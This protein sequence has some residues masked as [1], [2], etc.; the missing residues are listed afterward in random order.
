MSTNNR[1]DTNVVIE[2]YHQCE[3][4]NT[5]IFSDLQFAWIHVREEIEKDGLE[6][7]TLEPF[8]KVADGMEDKGKYMA[9]YGYGGSSCYIVSFSGGLN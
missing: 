9:A 4:K 3:L 2:Y 1:Y 8:E 6:K 5:L 7:W